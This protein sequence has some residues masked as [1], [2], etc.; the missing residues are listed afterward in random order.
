MQ[1]PIDM[2]FHTRPALRL[3]QGTNN[4]IDPSIPWSK[5]MNRSRYISLILYVVGSLGLSTL[6]EKDLNLECSRQGHCL[7]L[8]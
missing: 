6:H 7:G 3:G 4:M 8:T 1:C 2:I 5:A